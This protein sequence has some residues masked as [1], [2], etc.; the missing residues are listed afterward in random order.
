MQRSGEAPSVG[1]CL[2]VASEAVRTT[3]IRRLQI[4]SVLAWLVAV[5]IPARGQPAPTSLAAAP[6]SAT[7]QPDAPAAHVSAARLLEVPIETSLDDA[8]TRA[9][10]L[11]RQGNELLLARR[12]AEA[13]TL[14]Q[15]ALAL[16]ASY[17][18]AGNLGVA[19]IDAGKHRQAVEH[20]VFALRH[21]PVGASQE[22]LH[23]LLTLLAKERAQVVMLV[24]EVNL[25]GA[26][27]FVD[28]KP[29]GAALLRDE[30]FLE[31]GPRRVEAR[32]KGYV[33]AEASVTGEIGT[34]W[35]VSLTLE[36]EPPPLPPPWIAEPPPPPESGDDWPLRL[37]VVSLLMTI[38]V[39]VIA[40]AGLPWVRG[41]RVR[42]SRRW[43]RLHPKRRR[44]VA[45]AHRRR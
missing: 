19:E 37:A 14:Y 35:H 17:D 39:F 25:A 31:P 34:A 27:V 28:D 1:A 5:A 43:K 6:A 16:Q 38:A 8:R 44:L 18:I 4:A 29:I 12:S 45:R 36:R 3:P 23:R 30:L 42:L 11:T 26:E 40:K 21:F 33:T 10:N 32:Q 20:L 15:Q 24:V 9:E 2:P 13:E 41:L 22:P 7:A